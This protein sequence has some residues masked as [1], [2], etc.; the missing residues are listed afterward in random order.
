MAG[1]NNRGRGVEA[2]F[3]LVEV[4]VAGTLLLLI[5]VPTAYLIV[6]STKLVT[7]NKASVTAAQLAA[8]QLEADRT[9]ADTATWS[10]A[11][12]APSGSWPGYLTIPSPGIKYTISRSYGWCMDSQ[13][14]STWTTT[15]AGSTIPTFP[16][17]MVGYKEVVTVTW[18]TG[19][20]KASQ[21]LQ[22]P[23]TVITG[24]SGSIPTSAAS[25]PS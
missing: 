13:S 17:G 16:S 7:A 5:L 24:A 20:L 23:D 6:S 4:L 18:Q 25:C 15:A 3:T 8:S 2:G 22:A 19:S 1:T 21:I 14:Q 11:P 9:F 12:A 10:G